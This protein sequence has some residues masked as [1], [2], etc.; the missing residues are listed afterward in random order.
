MEVIERQEAEES[1]RLERLRLEEEA[2]K[3]HEEWCSSTGVPALARSTL[4]A[5]CPE[6][7]LHV[8]AQGLQAASYD[9][10]DII[11]A[12]GE[13]SD[14][15]LLVLEGEVAL[16]SKS[17]ESVGSLRK[18]GAVG[19][20]EALGLFGKRTV[21]VK[22]ATPCRILPVTRTAI[23]AALASEHGDMVRDGFQ[24]LVDCRRSQVDSG[25]PL[26][27]L[28][29]TAKVTDPSVRMVALHAERMPLDPDEVW[30]PLSAGDPC[31]PR[32]GIFLGGRAA[33]VAANGSEVMTLS[34]G[35]VVCESILAE[36]G[37]R[38][39][40]VSSDIE[41]YRVKVVDLIAASK[42]LEKAPD[43]FYQLRTLEKDTARL[44]RSRLVN[45]R[46]LTEVQ[47][48]HPCD[49]CIRDYT[50]RRKESIQRAKDMR[51]EKSDTAL[52]YSKGSVPQ[53]PLLPPDQFGTTA[54]R[55]W[56]K[57]PVQAPRYPIVKSKSRPKYL[58]NGMLH[59]YPAAQVALRLP[60]VN[61][62]P[63]LKTMETDKRA[64]SRRR[65]RAE[66]IAGM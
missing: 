62:E 61:S 44:L 6:D 56:E 54:F 36:F 39:R 19:E 8:V 27:S 52:G 23:E 57:V 31:G 16:E 49:S 9:V 40:A 35:T 4:L 43:W 30:E 29:T 10:G 1:A 42:L 14:S 21:T 46:G 15:M 3:Q 50:E 32:L 18:R 22:A 51:R 55:S 26:C 28:C 53:L 64:S 59:A 41:A 7:F 34:Q 47:K 45:A 25:R 66:M 37:A 5:G 11:A 12:A 17:G 58:P 63:K 38:I 48:E 60:K 20:P 33:I 13:D 2:R 24:A 65:Q